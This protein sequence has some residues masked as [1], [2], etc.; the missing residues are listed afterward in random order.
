MARQ[1]N[2]GQIQTGSLFNISSSYALTA[3]YVLNAVSSSFAQTA[4]FLNTLNQD[5]T[6]NG[7]LTLNGTASISYLNV[8]YETASVIYSSGSNQFGDAAND[9][10]TLYGNVIVPTG[11]VGIGTTT[12]N[13]K[14]DI[15]GSVNISGSGVQIPLQI[16][17][18]NTS[19]LFVSGSGNVGIGTTSPSRNL[20]VVGTTETTIRIRDTGGSSLELYQQATDS[21]LLATNALHTYT[22]GSLR[23]SITSTGNVGIGTI[24]PGYKLSVSASSTSDGIEV[25]QAGTSRILLRGDGVVNWGQTANYG[26]LTW[27]TGK[28]IIQGQ[29]G[30]ALSLGANGVADHLYIT[31]GSNV[32][33]G[34][35]TP[36]HKLDVIGNARIG[37]N[38]NASTSV[39]LNITA[40][41]SGY[42]SVIDFGFFDTFDAG[43]WHVG[44]KGATGAFF[45][46]NYSSGPETNV[47]TIST[48]NLVGIGTT[49]PSSRL[50][51]SGSARITDGLTVTGSLI[52]SGSTSIRGTLNQAS[53]SLASGLFAHA[54]GFA[55]T[56]LGDYSHAEGYGTNAIGNSS[57]A[58]G[59]TT[60]ATGEG[61]HAE[62]S[63]T[64]ANGQYSHAEG[65]GTIAQGA[66]QHVQ[67]QYNISSSAQGAF[68]VGNGTADGARSNLI[69]AS[70]SQVQ[71]TGSAR[72]TGSLVVTGSA[73]ITGSFIIQ[74]NSQ[75]SGSLRGQVTA[76]S[77]TSNTASINMSTNNFFTLTLLNSINGVTHINPTN[78]NPGQTVSIRITQSSTFPGSIS[79]PSSIKQASGSAYTA[80]AVSSAVD[81]VTLIAFD[82][83]TVYVSAI[84]RMI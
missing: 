80:S 82:A 33:I 47:L 55:V 58:E 72:I 57:H 32:G 44:R 31:T 22:S 25:I 67:G 65:L 8:A 18:G 36:E 14:L 56:A 78:I 59:N 74:G 13:A 41:G 60:T 62:G 64:V 6:F 75:V 10:Q 16:S 17:S 83:S 69:F 29:S 12:P 42:D 84:N 35:T 63:S 43:I 26:S 46:S 34:T 37:Y 79:F 24:A 45:I 39:L 54:Q 5:L 27:D 76:L 1:F 19:L 9:T 81:I 71:I 30:K 73:Q 48:A 50:D 70:G 4:S 23:L 49:T 40:G 11:S 77:V 28:A 68:I 2:P 52:V 20:D 21:Y 61:S 7:N 38:S 15:S 3:S 66:Y 53:A 51:V